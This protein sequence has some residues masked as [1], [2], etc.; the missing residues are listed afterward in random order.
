MRFYYEAEVSDDFEAGKYSAQQTNAIQNNLRFYE[1]AAD[2]LG[3]KNP[4]WLGSKSGKFLPNYED[5]VFYDWRGFNLQGADFGRHGS[6]KTSRATLLTMQFNFFVRV[7]GDR[8]LPC[9]VFDRKGGEHL[10][11]HEALKP[12]Y[13]KP[14][15]NLNLIPFGTEARQMNVM[16]SFL[17][18]ETQ[19]GREKI[20][21][22]KMSY[23][24][25]ENAP[26]GDDLLD[27]ALGI[28]ETSTESEAKKY[29]AA[30]R[31]KSEAV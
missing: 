1:K 4:I 25:F 6:G 22:F 9:V 16:P 24:D 23:A 31:I 13:A 18:G 17:E 27:R 26:D 29:D 14:L 15:R 8:G 20:Q 7:N 12:Q 10:A 11:N 19:Y 5:L 21:R 2:K 3:M 30:R 28:E